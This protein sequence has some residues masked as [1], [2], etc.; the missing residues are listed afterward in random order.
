[1]TSETND[2][3]TPARAATSSIV[4]RLPPLRPSVMSGSD[5]QRRA[6]DRGN[7]LPG[8]GLRRGDR[9]GDHVCG[10]ERVVDGAVLTHPAGSAGLPS[11]DALLATEHGGEELRGLDDLQV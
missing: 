8:A 9:R 1:M 11:P 7:R 10:G 5:G 4:G 2:L 6:G 3:E